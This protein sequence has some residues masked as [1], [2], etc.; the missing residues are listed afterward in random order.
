MALN[1][2]FHVSAQDFW[3]TMTRR[4][5]FYSLFGGCRLFTDADVMVAAMKGLS[6]WSMA[7]LTLRRRRRLDAGFRFDLPREL[8]RWFAVLPGLDR[9][10]RVETNVSSHSCAL[11]ALTARDGMKPLTFRFGPIDLA[12]DNW[13]LTRIALSGSVHRGL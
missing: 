9:L 12:Y 8:Q 6:S 3:M 10:L 7:E 4:C 13:P 2:G 1:E 5:C 11:G